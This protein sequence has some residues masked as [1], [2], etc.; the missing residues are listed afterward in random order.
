M[1]TKEFI[2]F[3]IWLHKRLPKLREEF[4]EELMKEY[5]KNL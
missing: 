1:E 4:D 5:E 3:H 2:K